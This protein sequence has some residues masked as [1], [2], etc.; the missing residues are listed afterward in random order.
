MLT[1]LDL[2]A[3]LAVQLSNMFVKLSYALVPILN[4]GNQSSLSIRRLFRRPVLFSV[5]L[6]KSHLRGAHCSSYVSQVLVHLG[7]PGV[8]ITDLG[9]QSLDLGFRPCQLLIPLP[10]QP[11]QFD[12][13]SSRLTRCFRRFRTKL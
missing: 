4:L 9:Q 7:Q 2:L 8:P 10:R 12:F 6:D 11:S 13:D 3:K 5:G 1:S